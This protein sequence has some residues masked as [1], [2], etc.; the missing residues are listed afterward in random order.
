MSPIAYTAPPASGSL[1]AA[2]AGPRTASDIARPIDQELEGLQAEVDALR[3][4]LNALRRRDETLNFHMHRID[5]ELRLA[6]R[7]Q[8]DFLPKSLPE[9][10]PVRFHTLFRPAGYV[11]GDLY[12]VMR[13]DEH[14]VGFYIADAVGH[15]MPA[16]LL[17]MFLKQAL[18]T[19]EI[20]AGTYRLLAPSETLARLNQSLLAQHLSSATFA[21]GLYG[22]IDTQSLTL[23][24]A[25]A[26]HPH[27]ILFRAD[28]R[29][30]TL[31][32]DGGLLGVFDD[33]P[34][35]DQTVQLRPG[36]RLIAF[37]DGVEVAFGGCAVAPDTER[38]THEIALLHD[39]PAEQILT[40]LATRI[41]QEGGSLDPKD[42]LTIV[43][44]EVAS[45]K[46]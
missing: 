29:T 41:D 15:G 43:I 22:S 36:D 37:T 19:K 39:L 25:R 1:I 35:A 2:P 12:D 8:Q 26:G 14:R 17:S 33:E 24:F 46:C 13:L 40:R 44:A 34:Y 4:E 11:S 42:D 6:A 20:L 28:G 16:A 5:E 9:V 7:L 31:Q 32:S 21:T 30:E 3:A 10:G 27:P 23:T 45:A 18:L 38:W